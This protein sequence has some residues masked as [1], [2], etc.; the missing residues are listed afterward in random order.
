METELSYFPLNKV[1]FLTPGSHR[2]GSLSN[3]RLVSHYRKCLKR[4]RLWKHRL[5]HVCLKGGPIT[6]HIRAIAI[7]IVPGPAATSEWADISRP[8]GMG[9]SLGLAR[10]ESFECTQS[11]PGSYKHY[12]T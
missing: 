10:E 9:Q 4:Y 12:L 7:P 2:V 11:S 1:F 6:A 5:H 3:D 8:P